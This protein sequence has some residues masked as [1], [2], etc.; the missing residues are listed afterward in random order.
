MKC[1]NCELYISRHDLR[2]AMKCLEELTEKM[3]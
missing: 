2:G 1:A 3:K